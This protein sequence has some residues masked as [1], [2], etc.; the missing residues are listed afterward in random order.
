MK[1]AAS[2]LKSVVFPLMLAL[3]PLIAGLT[4]TACHD[5]TRY[6]P[7]TIVSTEGLKSNSKLLKRALISAQS[8]SALFCISRTSCIVIWE[9]LA[10]AWVTLSSS[11]LA[12]SSEGFIIEKLEDSE[13]D[14][15]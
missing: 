11:L 1:L 15:K 6:I 14:P 2:P 9:V 4:P 8:S 5:Y 13:R 12:T 7:L 10:S 3:Y